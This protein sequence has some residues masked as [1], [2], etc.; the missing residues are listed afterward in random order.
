VHLA[1]SQEIL[2]SSTTHAVLIHIPNLIFFLCA[3]LFH[4]SYFSLYC[5]ILTTKSFHRWL[6]I[7]LQAGNPH[8]LKLIGVLE[9]G[10]INYLEPI[11]VSGADWS[12]MKLTFLAR[13][14]LQHPAP[15]IHHGNL[16]AQL[17]SMVTKAVVAL[18]H[19]CSCR[20][21][22][23]R[24]PRDHPPS[25]ELPAMPPNTEGRSPQT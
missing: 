8:Y 18:A 4:S 3:T 7:L 20:P 17:S 24:R 25:S 5:S 12:L 19:P 14:N 13:E 16:C 23:R 6:T 9:A 1:N 11:G 2:A 15:A 22:G 10:T 21:P